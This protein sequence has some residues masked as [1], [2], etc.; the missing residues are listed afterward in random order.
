MDEFNNQ[1]II[2]QQQR[3]SSEYQT[4]W[5]YVLLGYKLLLVVIGC[6]IAW[7]THKVKVCYL[8]DTR[9]VGLSVYNIALFSIVGLPL[10]F[11]IDGHVNTL[12]ACLSLFI[13]IPTTVS[14]CLLFVP[15]VGILNSASFKHMSC[16]RRKS[17]MVTDTNSKG[18]AMPS[19]FSPL[20]VLK[21][22]PTKIISK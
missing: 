20:S 5:L 22:V 6:Y 4:T 7:V 9:A 13:L 12:V 18:L 19:Q 8:N 15:K 16:V 14:L 2:P 21:T 11:L 1:S 17:S 3:C 10:Y